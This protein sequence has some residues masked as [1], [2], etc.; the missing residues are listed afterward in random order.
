MTSQLGITRPAN[1]YGLSRHRRWSDATMNDSINVD[2]GVELSCEALRRSY[3][4]LPYGSSSSR[5]FHPD[6][7]AT[8]ARLFG[9]TTPPIDRCRVLELGCSCGGNIIPIAFEL[10]GSR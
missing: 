7:L 2:T 5:L 4:E 1:E 10:P 6:T 9:I 8:V 3:N